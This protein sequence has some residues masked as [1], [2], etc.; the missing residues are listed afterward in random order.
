MDYGAF[1][2]HGW[3]ANVG[4]VGD[5]EEVFGIGTPD[6]ANGEILRGKVFSGLNTSRPIVRSITPG[7]SEQDEDAAEFVGTVLSRAFDSVWITW[8]NP[9]GNK[10]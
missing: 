2:E 4:A 8:Q 6:Q 9:A 3:R 5:S 7:T 1:M 10:V